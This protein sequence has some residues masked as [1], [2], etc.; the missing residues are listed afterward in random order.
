MSN[1]ET[2]KEMYEAFG[3]GDVPAIIEKLD[4]NVEWDTEIPAEGVPW[5]EPR[6]G[7]ANVPG[8]FE[9]LAPLNIT[10]FDPHTIF[11]EG[12]KVFALVAIE[13]T[14]AKGNPFNMPLEGHLWVFNS[15]GKVV[16]FQHV[17]D[18]A[19]HWRMANM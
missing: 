7:K 9:A 17:A 18:T 11:S 19:T 4:E 3:R 8:F 6:R 1:V 5:M 2:V 10:R 15:A 16:K 12:D 14:N 13:G